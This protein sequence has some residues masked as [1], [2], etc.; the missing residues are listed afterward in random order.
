M[1]DLNH[2]SGFV[3]GRPFIL[4]PPPVVEIIN[5]RIDQAMKLAR[6]KEV[7]RDYLGASRIG[8]P[9]ARKLAYEYLKVPGEEFTGRVLRIF[10]VGHNFEDL[11]ATWIRA[12]G[13]ELRTVNTRGHQFGFE[14]MHGKIKG[15]IDGVLTGGPDIGHVYPGGW[16]CKSANAKS[17]NDVVK[18]G[19]RES[20]PLYFSQCQTYMGYLDLPWFLLSF[21]NKDSQEIYHEVVKYDPSE[22]QRLSD[23]AVDIIRTTE[24]GLLP[25][26]ITD[27]PDFYVCRWCPFR[28]R[29]WT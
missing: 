16:E 9:C 25:A 13:F 26:R 27:N 15:H 2:G 5:D 4:G 28:D 10:E 19:V 1:I 6:A 7:P 20:K 12:A 8:E 18:K 17:W 3:Y 24:S 29:C 14:T 22:A 11:M 23:R 21:L